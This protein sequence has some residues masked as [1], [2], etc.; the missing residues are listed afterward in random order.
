MLTDCPSCKTDFGVTPAIQKMGHGQVRCGQCRKQFDA[1]E[2]MLDESEVEVAPE[3]PSA[4][5]SQASNELENSVDDQTFA[6]EV[7][8]EG[9]RIEISGR[10]PIQGDEDSAG[11]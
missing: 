9:S 6:E 1:I 7:V 2:C 5:Q 10:Y 4:P 3:Q 11:A 8:M